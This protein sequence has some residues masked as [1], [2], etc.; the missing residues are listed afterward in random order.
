[1]HERYFMALRRASSCSVR[2]IGLVL[3]LLVA[4]LNLPNAQDQIP[5]DDL[6]FRAYMAL[7]AAEKAEKEGRLL[8]SL[9]EYNESDS[10][11][12]QLSEYYP[13]WEASMVSQRRMLIAESVRTLKNRMSR[14]GG[15]NS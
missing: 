12:F 5:A 6:W 1:M 15:T 3:I 11:H 10:L 14:Q 9:Q 13:E 2:T 4:S 7:K 8:D